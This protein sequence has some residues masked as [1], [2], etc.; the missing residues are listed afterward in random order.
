MLTDHHTAVPHT[1]FLTT[2]TVKQHLCELLVELGSG[3][4]NIGDTVR[5]GNHSYYVVMYD[6]TTCKAVVKCQIVKTSGRGKNKSES[7]SL[8]DQQ[9]PSIIVGFVNI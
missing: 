4:S 8:K 3:I 7:T 5:K 1:S 2:P 6:K 9:Y